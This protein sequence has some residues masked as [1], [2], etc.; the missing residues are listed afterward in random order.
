MT[1][2]NTT[3]TYPT[4]Q[5]QQSITPIET[6]QKVPFASEFVVFSKQEDIELRCR[7]KYLEAQQIRLKTKVTELER[8][9]IFVK[10]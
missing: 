3:I 1:S 9:E 5:I 2:V 10:A 4:S 6:G 7:I 8:E